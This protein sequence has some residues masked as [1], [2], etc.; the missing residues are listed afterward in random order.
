MTADSG[1]A[2]TANDA[3]HRF[4]Y[5]ELGDQDLRDAIMA[6]PVEAES[7]TYPEIQID[8][9]NGQQAALMRLDHPV[10]LH[11]NGPLGDYPFAFNRQADIRMTG[12][13]GHGIADGMISGAVRIRGDAGDGA[14]AAMIGGTLAVYGTAGNRCGAGMRNG[15]IF[16]RGDVGDEAAIGAIGGTIVIGGDAGRRLGDAMSNVTVFIRGKAASLAEGVTEA[17]LRKREQL[18]LGLLLINASIRGDAN[19]FR[20][21]VPAAMFEAERARRGE[22]VPNWR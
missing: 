2:F 18:K 9:A 12:N 22:V 19:E 13:A 20:R 16:V 5:K 6:I 4:S 14:G 10:R 7:E 21:I 8:G 3:K 11:V 1:I 15:S 17:P